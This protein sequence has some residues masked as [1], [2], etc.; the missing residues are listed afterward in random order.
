[1]QKQTNTPSWLLRGRHY[2]PCPIP[3]DVGQSIWIREKLS[4]PCQESLHHGKL[5]KK[6]PNNVGIGNS[7][8]FFS[9]KMTRMN[10]VDTV[11]QQEHC[12]QC[13]FWNQWTPPERD[14]YIERQTYWISRQLFL[15]AEPWN[16]AYFHFSLNAVCKHSGY[17]HQTPKKIN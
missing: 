11:A 9:I 14:I 1:M 6:S 3:W 17:H 2:L 15:I 8:D 7:E 12:A 16:W 5:F 4:M 13:K 10:N